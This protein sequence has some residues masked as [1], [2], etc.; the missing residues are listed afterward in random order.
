MNPRGANAAADSDE[1]SPPKETASRRELK[2]GY[3]IIEFD[4]PKFNNERDIPI[5]GSG[6]ETPESEGGRMGAL[7]QPRARQPSLHGGQAARGPAAA[8]VAR[9]KVQDEVRELRANPDRQAAAQLRPDASYAAAPGP[10]EHE[11]MISS[12]SPVLEN[13]TPGLTSKGEET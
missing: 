13:N 7:L 4:T 9:P 1:R 11:G 8:S 5:A 3:F 10:S 2:A 6:G 12:E